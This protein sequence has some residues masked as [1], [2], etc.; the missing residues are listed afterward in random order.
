[1]PTPL[2]V[3]EAL[4]ALRLSQPFYEEAHEYFVGDIQEVFS[5]QK[6]RQLI[7]P[8]GDRYRVN[9]ARTPVDVLLERTTMN[10]I[11]SSDDAAVALLTT[12]WDDNELGQEAKDLHRMTYEYGDAY[13]IAWPNEDL[14]GN[15]EAYCH[16]PMNVRV[17]YD[18][19]APRRKSHAIHT[20]IE[21]GTGPDGNGLGE[22]L[23]Q[24]VAIYWP[25]YVEQWVT[26]ERID[27]GGML[28]VQSAIVGDETEFVPYIVDGAD[29][30]GIIVN[31]TPGI[32]PVFH[33][34]NGR[35][36]GRPEHAD[37]YGPQDMINK[38]NITMMAAVDYAGFPQRYVLTDSALNPD[39]ETDNFGPPPDDTLS[40]DDGLPGLDETSS[41]RAGP[42]E[43]WFLS[44][45][46]LGVGQ[47]ATSE[48][49][50]FLNATES[51]IKQMASVTD[52]PGY[53]F[54][55]SG[56][57]P[58]GESFRRAEAPLNKKLNDRLAMLNVTWHEFF[59][60]SLVVNGHE[61]SDAFIA[62]EPPEQFDDLDSWQTA[63][64]QQDAGVSRVQ[65]LVERGYS[66]EQA[67]QWDAEKKAAAPNTTPAPQTPPVPPAVA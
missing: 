51:L 30:D 26:R 61:P 48:T 45:A 39:D 47:F 5:S 59:D 16:D 42:G 11:T 66:E 15:I 56:Q 55:R 21:R 67:Q 38:L 9:F 28:G 37:A 52:V 20:W 33:F 18:P 27:A 1:M 49:Q 4:D 2:Y 25:E 62:W 7:G 36:Y 44:G 31:P 41:L 50:N 57:M 46:K 29:G 65:T 35:P 6:L 54:D 14:P 10:G 24:R 32:V 12:V 60:Y 63:Q 13:L 64:A 23:W 3:T 53:Y 8:T 19:Q 34:R 17:F 22:G 58:S 43:T 40:I